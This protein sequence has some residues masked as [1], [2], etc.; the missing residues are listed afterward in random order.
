[1]D[2]IFFLAIL[3]IFFCLFCVTTQ[4]TLY[5]GN[6]LDFSLLRSLVDKAYWPIYG[7][8][9]I[10]DEINDSEMACSKGEPCAEPSGVIF[11]YVMLMM[12][13]VGVNVLLL[14]L[15]IAMF[16]ATYTLVQDN[17]DTI[18]KFQKYRLV[19][20]YFGKIDNSNFI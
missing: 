8:M 16:S 13:M 3:F 11:S 1:M 10:L 4:A 19:F 2:L 7:E 5:P 14:N 6:R 9:K 17:A 15:L 20:E 12:Y 18:W